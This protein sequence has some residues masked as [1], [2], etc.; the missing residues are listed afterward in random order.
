MLVKLGKGDVL[1]TERQKNIGEGEVGREQQAY[2]SAEN[3]WQ[4]VSASV[5]MHLGDTFQEM[6]V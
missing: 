3:A 1:L 2:Q 5:L 6:G 4:H